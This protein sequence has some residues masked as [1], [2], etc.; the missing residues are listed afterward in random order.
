MWK[1]SYA[2]GGMA[3]GGGRRK[4]AGF[5]WAERKFYWGKDGAGERT[6]DTMLI[7]NGKLMA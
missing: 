1:H 2:Y 6:W 5:G 7:L 4:E 3:Q